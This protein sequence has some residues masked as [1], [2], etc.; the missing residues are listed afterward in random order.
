MGVE[1]FFNSLT[2][3]EKIK[4]NGIIVGLKDK[5]PSN[6]IYIDFNSVIHNISSETERDLNY[7]LYAI[8]LYEY[9]S[10]KYPLDS[11]SLST[12]EKY[13]YKTI[14][15]DKEIDIKFDVTKGI[16]LQNFID[17][18][19]KNNMD[20]IV[21]IK[22]KEHIVY[23]TT[24][25]IEPDAVKQIYIAFDGVPQ[26]SKVV[27]QKKRRYN[28]FV[29][30]ELRAKIYEEMKESLNDEAR[31]GFRKKYEEH[32]ISIDRGRITTRATLMDRVMYMLSDTKFKLEMQ[33]HH[34]VLEQIVISHVGVYGEGEKKIME[35][36][37]KLSETKQGTYT[38]Y[39]P[40]A[41]VVILGLICLNRMDVMSNVSILRFNQQSEEYDYVD[42]SALRQNIY[43]M[44]IQS[45]KIN[46]ME[47]LNPITITNDIAFIF[48]LF[49]NDFLPRMEAIDARNDIETL[50]TTYCEYLNRFGGQPLIFY[51]N[52]YRIKYDDRHNRGSLIG[53]LNILAENE[54]SLLKET[55]MAITY[56]NY[57]RLKTM[58]GVT[59]LLPVL[60]YYI[61][62]TN[63]IFKELKT[64][65]TNISTL[66]N[67]IQI[68]ETRKQVLENTIIL[69][70]STNANYM[71]Q[72]I[73][74][75]KKKDNIPE[76]ILDLFNMFV[77]ELCKKIKDCIQTEKDGAK[78]YYFGKLR[79]E[80]YETD[81]IDIPF[82]ENNIKETLPH[83]LCEITDY[84]K[85]CYKLDRKLMQYESKLNSV[86]F[87]L[88]STNIISNHSKHDKP[89]YVLIT[90][91]NNDIAVKSY[92]QSFF[93]I[94]GDDIVKADED[95]HKIVYEYTLGLMWIFDFY[96]NKNNADRNMTK[97]STWMYP[98]H[99]APL[100]SQII[101]YV[102]GVQIQNLLTDINKSYVDRSDYLNILEHYMYITP[103][104]RMH[105]IPE[106]YIEFIEENTSIY[107]NLSESANRIW[108]G[109]RVW[110][111]IDCKRIN[112]LSKCNLLEV[113]HVSYNDYFS[114][115]K[116]LRENTDVPRLDVFN[117]I[118]KCEHQTGGNVNIGNDHNKL[119]YYKNYFKML[120]MKTGIIKYKKYYKTLK[121][122]LENQSLDLK[123][124]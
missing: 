103:K 35:D 89:A 106:K 24:K 50:I 11:T 37:I 45:V 44:V 83:P 112:F 52:G 61:P 58:L 56:K 107:P 54:E 51:E 16:T 40:D 22:I 118:H 113:K 85:E 87:D 116:L 117:I 98:Y 72:F 78:K 73:V 68:D 64:I 110:E 14:V 47:Y 26:M 108:S 28:G 80:H 9:D 17:T 30:G 5:I 123:I 105:N 34:P 75:E 79:L 92:Y 15:D 60:K 95:L 3:V 99:R 124:I 102:R 111:I 65:A 91:R 70:Q 42:I 100:L 109:D 67:E 97:V 69:E 4:T 29:I 86:N 25:L 49:G 18:F 90:G 48:T 2:Q 115:I 21:L 74:F 8:I 94:T 76:N 59:K 63:K 120:Y 32:K 10:N 84:D 33:I 55:Y 66:S 36:I 6:Y 101:Y 57:R 82:H 41:D 114:K 122:Q 38:I 62:I 53:Y 121:N 27:E 31:G 96:F 13:S 119:E 43:D 88:G 19:P 23:I 81:K 71:K 46:N 77:N 12:I 20:E 7:L 1:R 104:N 93:G 39:S